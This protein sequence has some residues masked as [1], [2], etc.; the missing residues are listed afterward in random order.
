M[1]NWVRNIIRMKDI[2]DKPLFCDPGMCD[3]CQH[4]GDGD[5][6]CN[7]HSK[8]PVMVVEDWMPTLASRNCPKRRRNTEKGG[9]Q[10]GV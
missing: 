10:N 9:M 4:I 3:N 6:I 5:F 1:P 8:E 2:T 7:A